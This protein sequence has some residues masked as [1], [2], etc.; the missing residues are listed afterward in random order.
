MQVDVR[1][2]GSTPGSRRSPGGGRSNPLQYSCLADPTD[3]RAWRVTVIGVAQSWTLLKQLS[4]HARMLIL[5]WVANPFYRGSSW[6]RDWSWVS[7]IA[8]K[9]FIIWATREALY[10]S[11]NTCLSIYCINGIL[12]NFQSYSFLNQRVRVELKLVNRAD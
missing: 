6:L 8:G 5:E 4:T 2:G 3:R 1:D 7:C 9:F 11:Y 12:V 10:V